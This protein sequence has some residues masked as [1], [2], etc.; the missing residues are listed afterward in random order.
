M[1]DMSEDWSHAYQNNNDPSTVFIYALLQIVGNQVE[2]HY[3]KS[4][5]ANY[6]G[7][8]WHGTSG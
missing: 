4:E 3:C 1:Y 7:S 2:L 5:I 8:Q 6:V